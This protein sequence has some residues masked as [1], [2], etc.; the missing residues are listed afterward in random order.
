MSRIPFAPEVF[1]AW[2]AQMSVEKARIDEYAAMLNIDRPLAGKLLGASARA[3]IDPVEK[4]GPGAQREYLMPLVHSAAV[5]PPAEMIAAAAEELDDELLAK[6]A[7]RGAAQLF[8]NQA[9]RDAQSGLSAASSI[10]AE[11]RRAA[12]MGLG[13]P[14]EQPSSFTHG[15]RTVFSQPGLGLNEIRDV[16]DVPRFDKKLSVRGPHGSGG[17]PEA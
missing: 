12:A 3:F 11:V 14:A 10:A 5:E 15:G 1:F 13:S 17:G 9:E 8:I 7:I 2:E 6:R 16:P 4:A